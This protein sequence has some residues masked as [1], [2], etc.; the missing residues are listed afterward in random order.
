MC[1][2]PHVSRFTFHA[3]LLVSRPPSRFTPA[4]T[5]LEMLVTLALMALL[6]TVVTIS[7]AGPWRAAR[8][9]DA[10][11]EL[12][13]YDRGTREWC[14]RFAIQ[15]AIVFD[16]DRATVRRAAEPREGGSGPGAQPAKLHLP[17]AFRIARVVSRGRSHAAGEAVL[18]CSARGQTPS[19]AVLLS[20]PGGQQQW[21]VVA[22]LTGKAMTA[23]DEREVEAIFDALSGDS[24]SGGDD[25]R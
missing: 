15:G 8:A 21:V 1:E 11:D 5:L 23:G 24:L 18:Q 3:C 13:H 22:G 16:L 9:Q 6:A 7:L 17:G 4:F 20:G 10:A 19:Y 25:A 2:S 12:L 14:R